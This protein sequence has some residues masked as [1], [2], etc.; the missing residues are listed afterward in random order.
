MTENKTNQEIIDDFQKLYYQNEITW[1]GL[2][3]MGVYIQKMPTDLLIYQE[4]LY[5]LRPDLII[6]T[7]T[8]FG[9]SAYYLANICDLLG[10]GKIISIDINSDINRPF[11]PRITYIKGSSTAPSIIE[12]VKKQITPNMTVMVILDSD[13]TK[14]HVQ[15]ELNLYSKLV[16]KD[17][18]LIV[19]GSCI[20]GHALIPNFGPG[21]YEAI[22][23]FL[24]INQ[25]FA[26]D[27]SR[28]KLMLTFNP[29]GYL[30][31]VL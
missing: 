2:T 7:G 30:R 16:T 9:G 29:N 27:K 21:P 18:Y 22:D 25:E 12:Q 1:K 14:A 4:I 17:Q 26:I 8:M 24:S 20:N 23:E 15:Q 19:E 13:H 28:E 11:H 3:W 5:E 31:K 6:E 10:G